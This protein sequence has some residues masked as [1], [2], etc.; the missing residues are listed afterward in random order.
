MDAAFKGSVGCE[1]F[2]GGLDVL[3]IPTDLKGSVV[4]V[5]REKLRVNKTPQWPRSVRTDPPQMLMRF[6]STTNVCSFGVSLRS[7]LVICNL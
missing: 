3:A 1:F 4:A 5:N 6:V 2:V 7:Q